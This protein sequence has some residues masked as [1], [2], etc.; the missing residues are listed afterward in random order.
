M[1]KARKFH[2]HRE[3]ADSL[4]QAVRPYLNE[5][6]LSVFPKKTI[7]F[8]PIESPH[9]VYLVM[10][11]RVRVFLDYV[12]GKEFTLTVL[13]KGD[14]YSGHARG[15]GMAIEET[16]IAFIP[17]RVFQ[18]IMKDNPAFVT[19]VV[20]VLGDALKNSL[21]VIEN[22]AFRDVE[23][24]FVDFIVRSIQK[25]GVCTPEGTV[26][27]LGLNQEEIASAIGSTRQ[28]VSSISRKF[29]NQ[30]I[31]KMANRQVVVLDYERLITFHTVG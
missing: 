18:N 29:E 10:K 28:T 16:E 3:L 30:G 5:C 1:K 8:K 23:Q 11:G 17:I 12:D 19:S 14:A 4:L 26:I 31:L 2:T 21:D 20:A 24:R 9:C 27:E 22:L 25:E 13:K 15:Y 7:V 6:N